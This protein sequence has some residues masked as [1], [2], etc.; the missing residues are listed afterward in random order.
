[1]RRPA[2]IALL[3]LGAV[4]LAGCGGKESSR[5]RRRRSIGT[6]PKPTDD[7]P[8]R[9]GASS[10]RATSTAGKPIFASA[11]CGELPHARGGERERDRRAEP[12]HAQARLWR[13]R[14]AGDNGGGEMPAFKAQLSTQQIADVAAYVVTSTGGTA[15]ELPAEFPRPSPPSRSTSTGR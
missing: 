3:S 12:R 15:L 14:G 13:D 10:S 8:G 6:V 2:V 5:P 1:M 9:P 4:L 11:G 7:V